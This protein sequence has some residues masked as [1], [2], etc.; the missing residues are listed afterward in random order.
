VPP[1]LI[2]IANV[3]SIREKIRPLVTGVRYLGAVST[4]YEPLPFTVGITTCYDSDCPGFESGIRGV[5]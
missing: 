1:K 4:L 5:G 2:P 3:V